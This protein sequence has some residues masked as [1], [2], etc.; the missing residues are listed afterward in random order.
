MPRRSL[1]LATARPALGVASGAMNVMARYRTGL[2]LEGVMKA[3]QLSIP[4]ERPAGL[5]LVTNPLT[6]RWRAPIPKRATARA[7]RR[8]TR[9]STFGRAVSLADFEASPPLPA[10]PRAPM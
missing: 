8:P 1:P 5:T 10:S 7:R 9:C 4:L 6:C 3:G 2:G